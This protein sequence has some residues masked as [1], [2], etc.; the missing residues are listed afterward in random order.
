MIAGDD[1]VDQE[2]CRRPPVWFTWSPLLLD[3]SWPC[4]LYHSIAVGTLGCP[5]IV[6]IAPVGCRRNTVSILEFEF[7][8]VGHHMHSPWRHILRYARRWALQDSATAAELQ[9]SS[10]ECSEK[11]CQ[12][13]HKLGCYAISSRCRGRAS[14][15]S[16]LWHIYHH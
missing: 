6:G 7:T 12:S 16:H 8:P 4:G 11:E 14:I 13:H 1:E 2:V 9:L 15:A 3:T 5:I 10:G